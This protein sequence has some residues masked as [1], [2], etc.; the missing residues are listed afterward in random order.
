M[1]Y[2]LVLVTPTVLWGACVYIMDLCCEW[3]ITI[4]TCL[5]PHPFLPH[6]SLTP[7][8]TLPPSHLPQPSL[9]HPSL[10]PPSTLPHPSLTEQMDDD[11]EEQMD[12]T[13][14]GHGS[15][16]TPVIVSVQGEGGWEEEGE[17]RIDGWM[18]GWMD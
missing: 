3:C 12:Q 6:T 13:I 5:L 1:C 16:R 10:T 14:L 8:S 9:P 15:T 11:E 17:G 7:P 18:D 4:E 2:C